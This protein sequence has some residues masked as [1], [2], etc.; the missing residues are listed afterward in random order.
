MEQWGPGGGWGPM[1][2]RDRRGVA[3][4]L[5]AKQRGMEAWCQSAEVP[6]REMGRR[7]GQGGR[8]GPAQ[9]GGGGEVSFGGA[10]CGHPGNMA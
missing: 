7:M 10:E 3:E 5:M 2:R 9:A 1:S 6:W 8:L 4:L